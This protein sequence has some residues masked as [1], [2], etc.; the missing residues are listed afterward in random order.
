M[1]I[2]EENELRDQLKAVTA[3]RNQYHA[4][5][6]DLRLKNVEEKQAD[7]E[8]RLRPLEEGQVKANVIYSLFVGNGLLS[9]FALVKVF[10]K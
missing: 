6:V 9:I 3:E 5:L 10:M 7:H 2:T 4:A 1:T 8:C